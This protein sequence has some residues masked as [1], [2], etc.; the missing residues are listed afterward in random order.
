MR[1]DRMARLVES[2]P[3]WLI[4]PRVRT[5]AGAPPA[6]A[7][8]S[9]LPRGHRRRRVRRCR[10]DARKLSTW[11]ARMSA[12]RCPRD[13]HRLYFVFVVETRALVTLTRHVEPAAAAR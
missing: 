13:G 7:A 10:G 5:S 9:L 4:E 8:A 2:T 3:G 12:A 1:R 11:P 6:A